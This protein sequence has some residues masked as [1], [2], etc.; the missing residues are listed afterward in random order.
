[1]N[2]AQWAAV[3]VLAGAAGRAADRFDRRRLV[4]AMQLTAAALT[5]ALALATGAGLTTAPVVV[6]FALALGATAALTTPALG[7]IVPAL[8]ERE[9]LPSAVALNS[10]TYNLARALGPVLGVVLIANLG[11]AAAF[12]LTALSYLALV[13]AL[14]AVRP[15]PRPAERREGPLRLA[16]TVR[17]VRGDP[18]LLASLVVVGAASLAMDPVTT[19]TPAFSTRVFGRPDT[20]TGYLV[21]AFGTGAV[22]AAFL[23]GG[24]WRPSFGWM[25]AA[26]GCLFAGVTAFAL[27]DHAWVGLAALYVAGFGFLSCVTL[28]T[29]L[30]Q[31]SVDDAHRGRAMA[32]WSLSFQGTRPFGSLFDGAVA[33]AVGLRVA[34]LAMALP[35]LVAAVAVLAL[36]RAAGRSRP[37]P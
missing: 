2:F 33:A 8:V 12:G 13:V 18:R 11:F 34:A 24:R 1:V 9:A 3:L 15:A 36:R 25:V 37:A 16:D 19:L 30:L 32:L 29:S 27:S 6:G 35:A 4:V 5:A 14:L 10:V 20:F 28:A 21:G 22:S 23:V 7:A 26:L 17:L 31:L